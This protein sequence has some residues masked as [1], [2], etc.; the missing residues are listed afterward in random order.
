MKRFTLLFLLLGLISSNS[1][2]MNYLTRV[3]ANEAQEEKPPA[4]TS[5]ENI[6][7]PGSDVSSEET[8][9][10]NSPVQ[11]IERKAEQDIVYS[12]QAGSHKKKEYAESEA[13]RLKKMGFNAYVQTA[14]RKRKT[15]YILKLGDFSTREEALKIQS[16]LSQ[17]VPELKSYIVQGKAVSQAKTEDTGKKETIALEPSGQKVEQKVV[18]SIQVGSHQNK[19]YADSDADRLKQ[20]GFKSYVQTVIYKGETW[21]RVKVGDFS[22]RGEAETKQSELRE[23][24]PELNASLVEEKIDAIAQ[25]AAQDNKVVKQK[26]AKESK[27]IAQKDAQANKVIAQKVVQ[28]GGYSI[29]VGSHQNKEYAESDSERL[30]QMEFPSYVQTVLLNGETWYRVKVGDFSSR[31]EAETK[32]S[33]LREKAPE[34]DSYLMQEE[35]KPIAQKD[36]QESVYS[37]QVGSHQNREYADSESNRLKEMGLSSYVQTVI[38][39]GETWYRV[40]VGDFSSRGEAETIQTELRET[41]P[42]LNAYLVE[43]KAAS[44]KT[45]SVEETISIL[46][47]KDT[48]SISED[49]EEALSEI[50]AEEGVEGAIPEA[51]ALAKKKQKIALDFENAD[52]K[53]VITALAEIV[54]INYIIDPK[55]R[56]TVNIHTTGE[57]PVEGVFP[58]LETIFEI[59]NVA[60]VKVGDIYKIIPVKDAEKQPLIPQVGVQ[61]EDPTSPDRIMLQIIPLRYI[62]SQEME[63]I[64][65]RFLGKGG[66][67]INYPDRNIL[68]IVD[69]AGNMQK[70]L[71]LIDTIDQSIFETMHVKFYELE[72]SEAKDIAKELEDLFAALGLDTKAKKGG[73]GEVVR[74]IPIERMNIVLAVSSMAEIFEKVTEWVEKLDGVREDLE[75]QIFIYFVENAKALDIGDIIK[76]LYGESKKVRDK[77]EPT[78]T[79][80]RTDRRTKKPV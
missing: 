32:Q 59:N 51:E 48:S 17:K 27:V 44:E 15:W 42:E 75:E 16:E 1:G 55:V 13:L 26:D 72:E 2:I 31:V 62:A 6:E 8:M 22:S 35:S 28:E 36:A 41:A 67:I 45:V 73:G 53:E 77:R 5:A 63:K 66:D 7:P 56:G 37:I 71:T 40:K 20:M 25:K 78:R 49:V 80:R 52:I 10:K 46:P 58:I 69:T 30:K 76:E 43:E 9:K 33:E 57:I 34:F 4:A 64:L 54:E 50:K 23:K 18:Y 74:F 29:Q 79:T 61:P 21:Y 24:A 38:L 65:K 70:L 47:E 14:L 60:A 39:K 68:I 3:E 19:E 11:A 12:I